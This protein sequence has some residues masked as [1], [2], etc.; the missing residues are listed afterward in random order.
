MFQTLNLEES[1][2]NNILIS[3]LYG[4]NDDLRVLEKQNQFLKVKF[5]CLICM[6]V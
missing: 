3:K 6:L 5:K 2:E 4:L 1:K